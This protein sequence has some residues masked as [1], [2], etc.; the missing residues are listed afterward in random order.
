MKPEKIEIPA[1][2]KEQLAYFDS[3]PKEKASLPVPPLMK[4]RVMLK[5][6]PI[7]HIRAILLTILILSFSPLTI[8]L[9]TDWNFLLHTGILHVILATSGML[10]L[11]FAV[12]IGIYLV[13]YKNPYTKEWKNKLGFDE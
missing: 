1:D 9:F 3:P 4:K 8:I 13:Q 2:L 7:R 10:F 12:L 5:I 11:L 6:I